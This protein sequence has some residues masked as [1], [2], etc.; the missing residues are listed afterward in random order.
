MAGNTQKAFAIPI[1]GSPITVINHLFGKIPKGAIIKS[2]I[3]EQNNPI[4]NI[5]FLSMHFNNFGTILIQMIYDM[6]NHPNNKLA[7]S[8]TI[9]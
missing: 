7:I 1:N 3:Q 6:V 5:I 8:S 2:P 4:V 9:L